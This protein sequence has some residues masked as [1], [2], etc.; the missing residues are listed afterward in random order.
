MS[1]I[2]T[3]HYADE[4]DYQ[5]G[6]EDE[7]NG[8]LLGSLEDLATPVV[9]LLGIDSVILARKGKKQALDD[10][11]NNI[12]CGGHDPEGKDLFDD[13]KARGKWTCLPVPASD[14]LRAWQYTFATTDDGK[15][16]KRVIL[17]IRERKLDC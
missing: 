13:V 2:F 17:I 3:A 16:T 5:R 10:Y 9:T 7:A 8:D 14:D 1:T 6:L 15:E 4:T 11:A 12:S